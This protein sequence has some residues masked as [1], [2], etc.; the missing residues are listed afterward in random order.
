V[1]DHNAPTLD[2]VMPVYNEEGC[3]REVVRT[4]DEVIL[5]PIP[6]ARLIAVDDGSRD[7]TPEIL[8]ELA[9]ELPAVTVR[10]KPNGGH[11]DALLCGLRCAE[12]PWLFLVDSDNQFELRDFAPLWEHREEADLLMG[13]RRVRHDPLL[14]LVITRILRLMLRV[15]FGAGLRDANVPFKLVRRE[16]WERAAPVIGP[17]ALVPSIFLAVAAA[18]LGYRIAE[19]PVTHYARET[20]TV[21][22]RKWKLLRFCARA[23]V[24]LLA[25]GRRLRREARAPGQKPPPRA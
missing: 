5:R 15:L 23:F 13:F 9:A 8:D 3:V 19:F 11:G 1:S 12:A 25:F 16:L 6:G 20:G 4:L 22:I 10:H 7:A 14:R 24:Q 18:R 2:V 17:D 21:S